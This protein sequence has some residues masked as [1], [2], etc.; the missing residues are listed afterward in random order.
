VAR[1]DGTGTRTTTK[2]RCAC[3]VRRCR[4]AGG[5]DGGRGYGREGQ[6]KH[7]RQGG[8]YRRI[9]TRIDKHRY[10]WHYG[11]RHLRRVPGA[12]AR[13]RAI[14]GGAGTKTKTRDEM[15]GACGGCW[16]G[17]VW[18]RWTEI[19]S[20]VRHQRKH[21][22]RRGGTPHSQAQ[23]SPRVESTGEAGERRRMRCIMSFT[24]SGKRRAGGVAGEGREEPA[25]GCP[26]AFTSGGCYLV[27][28][29]FAGAPLMSSGGSSSRIPSGDA[30]GHRQRMCRA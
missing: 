23:A 14:G 22:T 20:D 5:A 1:R 24:T 9:H 11:R 13:L 17:A 10:K 29:C 30:W 8:G 4:V 21:K 28:L 26:L 6:R 15:R 7:E 18:V 27:V 12:D 25:A 19:R 16:G 3:G 2:T